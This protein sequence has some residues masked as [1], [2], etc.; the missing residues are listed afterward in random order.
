MPEAMTIARPYARAAFAQAREE[1]Q[2]AEWSQGLGLLCR[3]VSEPRLQAL[4]GDPRLGRGRLNRLLLEAL[5]PCSRSLENFLRLLVQAGR[6]PVLA[7]VYEIFESLR[8]QAEGLV[9]VRVQ[10][11]FPLTEEQRV[12]LT[13]A[14]AR[15]F[16]GQVQL[17]EEVDAGLIGGVVLRKGDTVIDA[18]LQGRLQRLRALLAEA[19][20]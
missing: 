6:L 17:E 14:L 15:R 19:S 10:S 1:G 11:A 7:A 20:V 8:A 12:F 2:L 5:P 16:G 13:R 3:M 9:R 4:I 18:S